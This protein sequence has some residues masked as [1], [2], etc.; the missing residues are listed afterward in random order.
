MITLCFALNF[1]AR[2]GVFQ[3]IVRY[4]G[5]KILWRAGKF[6]AKQRVVVVGVVGLVFMWIYIRGLLLGGLY[7]YELHTTYPQTINPAFQLSG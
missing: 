4:I 3:A 7:N 2:R 5:R 6:E 1:P